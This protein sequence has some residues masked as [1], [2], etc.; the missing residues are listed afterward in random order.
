MRRWRANELESLK[1]CDV[2]EWKG[3]RDAR[4]TYLSTSLAHV[5]LLASVDTLMDGQG[6]ALDELL[7]AVGVIAHVRTDPA[8]DT[9]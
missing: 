1:G 2:L 5:G 8:V 4:R 3:T 9:F 6:R 7:P